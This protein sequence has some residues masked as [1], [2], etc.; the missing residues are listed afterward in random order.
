M[1]T[2]ERKKKR[3]KVIPCILKDRPVRSCTHRVGNKATF[4]RLAV[5]N[6]SDMCAQCI[7]QQLG[8]PMTVHHKR[9]SVKL[10]PLGHVVM[11]RAMEPTA[12]D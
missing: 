11:S 6:L 7:E 8:Y 9:I 2:K 10:I 5:K 3:K 4:F 1:T 12:S